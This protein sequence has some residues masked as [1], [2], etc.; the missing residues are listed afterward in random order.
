MQRKEHDGASKRNFPIMGQK[1]TI[2]FLINHNK[3]KELE[4]VDMYNLL[5]LN[6]SLIAKNS[7]GQVRKKNWN[8]HLPGPNHLPMKSQ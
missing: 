4:I 3:L 2:I 1:E 8:T 5:S 7:P 6:H